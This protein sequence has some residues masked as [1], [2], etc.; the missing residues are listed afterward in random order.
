MDMWRPYIDATTESVPGAKIV[1]DLYH[2]VA[3]F[4]QVID[5]VRI[6]EYLRA[7]ERDRAVYKGA[8]YLLLKKRIR[9]KRRTDW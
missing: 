2:V 9:R 8:K 3:S 6:T 1:F 7:S 4:N 5:R